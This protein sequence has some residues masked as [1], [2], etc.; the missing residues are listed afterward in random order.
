MRCPELVGPR[1]IG[2][3]GVAGCH[4][5]SDDLLGGE[6]VGVSVEG[7]CFLLLRLPSTSDEVVV[8][9]AFTSIHRDV[10]PARV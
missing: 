4:P 10:H 2:A 7:D 8:E 9:T 3:F 1:R 5:F 6:T